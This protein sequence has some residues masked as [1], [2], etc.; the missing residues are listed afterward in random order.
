MPGTFPWSWSVRA[1][2][3]AASNKERLK[4]LAQ[5]RFRFHQHPEAA[6]RATLSLRA[7][8]PWMSPALAAQMGAYGVD[9]ADP[10]VTEVAGMALGRRYRR[11][12]VDGG[13]RRNPN[14]VRNV[15]R[16]AQSPLWDAMD[17]YA[18]P[19]PTL[20][21][22]TRAGPEPIDDA[23]WETA[24]RYSDEEQGVTD[25]YGT[26]SEGAPAPMA[27][28]IGGGLPMSQTQDTSRNLAVEGADTAAA[29]EIA[30]Y[31][32]GID[33]TVS[34]LRRGGLTFQG[35]PLPGGEVSPSDVA[36]ALTGPDR[37]QIRDTLEAKRGQL[38]AQYEGLAGSSYPDLPDGV[39]P[40]MRA[41]YDGIVS[42][43]DDVIAPARQSIGP[44]LDVAGVSLNV[45]DIE[46]TFQTGL[47][48]TVR[49]ATMAMDSLW[50]AGQARFR[51]MVDDPSAGEL[52][53]TLNPLLSV[54]AVVG[55][56][57]TGGERT[58]IADVA[59]QTD[60][61]IT[62]QHLAETGDWADV[63]SGYFV[64]RDSGVGQTRLENEQRHG[65]IGGHVITMGRFAADAAGLEP[66]TVPFDVVSG[67]V[68]LGWILVE[69]GGALVDAA[70]RSGRAGQ[71]LAHAGGF[72]A[73]RSISPAHFDEWLRGD[74]ARVLQ[75]L[76]DL[77]PDDPQQIYRSWQ[78]ASRRGGGSAMPRWAYHDMASGP[79]GDVGFVEEMARNYTGMGYQSP[80][81]PLRDGV[82]P[83]VAFRRRLSE[84]RLAQ[85]SPET[86]D[87]ALDVYDADGFVGML[88]S[89]LRNARVSE[90][91]V[92]RIVFRAYDEGFTYPS[93][94]RV[95]QLERELGEL[96]DE[97][98]V[99]F[100]GEEMDATV[101]RAEIEDTI[102][103]LRPGLFINRPTPNKNVLFQIWEEA[104]KA[105]R[106][107]LIEAGADEGLAIDRTFLAETGRRVD[108]NM[109]DDHSTEGLY[110]LRLV[111][112]DDGSQVADHVRPWA[113]IDGEHTTDMSSPS[114]AHLAAEHLAR[115]LPLEN[116]YRQLARLTRSVPNQV[117]TSWLSSRNTGQ[118]FSA[119]KG[120][121]EIF[122]NRV[123]KP[124]R[125][126][127]PAWPL[128][129][130]G[131]EQFRIAATGF[132]SAIS[133][134]LSFV[135][136][137]MG[138][139][140]DGRIASMIDDAEIGVELA[141][142]GRVAATQL[143]SNTTDA[144][145]R[146]WDVVSEFVASQNRASRN[147][148]I[149]T[150]GGSGG[151]FDPKAYLNAG[152]EVTPGFV[153]AWTDLLARMHSDDIT[154]RV[155]QIELG[156]DS[157]FSSID[158]LIEAGGAA[159][160]NS[161][162]VR[163]AGPDAQGAWIRNTRADLMDAGD[164]RLPLG[165]RGDRTFAERYAAGDDRI[166]NWD[167]YI[168]SVQV[169][170][171]EV[172]G[173]DPELMHT[174]ARGRFS[175]GLSLDTPNTTRINKKAAARLEGDFLDRAPGAVSGDVSHYEKATG[176]TSRSAAV[177]EGYDRVLE[178]MY[179][180]LGATPTDRLSRSPA[181]RQFYLRRMQQLLPN[182]TAEA[183]QQFLRN[184]EE[185][186]KVP[187]SAWHIRLS[188]YIGDAD[189]VTTP[190]LASLRNAAGAGV[191]DLDL[192]F[193][194]ELAKYAALD[195]T[196][197]LLYDV[198]RRGLF[199]DAAR[200][201]FPFGEAWKEVFT[202]WMQLLGQRPG[203]V[204]QRASQVVQAAG[205]EVQPWEDVI[206]DPSQHGFI[207]TNS[208]GEAVFSYPASEWVTAALSGTPV[209][210]TG[211]LNGLTMLNSVIPGL[212]PVIQMPLSASD[213]FRDSPALQG[214]REV[215]FPYGLGD[216]PTDS[217]AGAGMAIADTILSPAAQRFVIG[218]VTAP[219]DDR[220]FLN[221]VFDVMR[222]R[223]SAGLGSTGSESEIRELTQDSQRSAGLLY[224][225]RGLAGMVLPSAPI[226]EQMIE[227][228]NGGPLLMLRALT[229][230][231]RQYQQEDWQTASQ[232][233]LT[234]YGEQ[235]M[236]VIQPKTVATTS[237]LPVTEEADA[238]V[239]SHPGI[240]DEYPLTFGLW[241]PG[242][243]GDSDFDF[244]AYNRYAR[245][246]V[247]RTLGRELSTDDLVYLA[248]DRVASNI[249]RETEAGLL[250]QPDAVTE[251]GNLT[252]EA[253]AYLS[254]TVR[255]DLRNRYPGFGSDGLE[256][257]P[258][259]DELRDAI[260]GP[261]ELNAEVRRAVND[262]RV[263]EPLRDA[264][265]T[266]LEVHDEAMTVW[267]PEQGSQ[268]YY[269]SIGTSGIRTYMRTVVYPGIREDLPAEYQSRWDVIFD[270]LFDRVMLEEGEDPTAN[271][272]GIAA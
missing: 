4:R 90:D 190:T 50:Q 193:A 256:R 229:D 32:P 97:G 93:R 173:R 214:V 58:G 202:R 46:D 200:I 125:L 188:A 88:E 151:R 171:F 116:D 258:S 86:G 205:G 236:L 195:N 99:V 165:Q 266:Y 207:F 244:D 155:A 157:Q 28:G 114:F 199:M 140:R 23:T 271:D 82:A 211:S 16:P 112:R 34:H 179:A 76:A 107:R 66:D 42:A 133:H 215:L 216:D 2:V 187:D 41:V 73:T 62:L 43:L 210:F 160:R 249:Y 269:E 184:A 257:G 185:L 239:Q 177:T 19:K 255:Q 38:E 91:E 74:G 168:E 252:E 218:A 223:V 72:A 139:R 123:W 230:I 267:A 212:G 54:P 265:R 268:T 65:L 197:W 59:Q 198:N 142:G 24:R 176:D 146:P 263:P 240:M 40:S 209:E 161:D 213:W 101:A 158:E 33:A 44:D 95:Q 174:V 98:P 121:D 17:R 208:T 14:E 105:K 18:E 129:V 77:D 169:R 122:M 154:R 201:V 69:P 241:A 251:N 148:I 31:L 259:T 163:L 254:T 137:V 130:V 115:Y 175:D 84:S 150:G 172:T 94:V 228:E 9:V 156:I 20:E 145:G 226:P 242:N 21:L 48:G 250:A 132:D 143:G 248:N 26:A 35:I 108:Q 237:M 96:P 83:G 246:R 147:W 89:S 71:A 192:E 217:W 204:T 8:Y 232:R 36:D 113:Q 170:L 262:E 272:L 221:S 260:G 55:D 166:L 63:G 117:L 79:V 178:R 238:W 70:A 118:L 270:R 110:W 186:M 64:G 57:L 119:W 51:Q 203:T 245:D 227:S 80:G 243:T 5:D 222:Y 191:G 144:L 87:R 120:I 53:T 25:F 100:R 67:L 131:E 29:R 135:S 30:P 206:E 149:P 27:G 196:R 224:M 52:F 182:M 11:G 167:D 6:A 106:E 152:G 128:R 45:G 78:A 111:T 180:L 159:A 127:R 183:Q 103:E 68:D 75:H 124:S 60:L 92:A 162:E 234:D 141:T 81:V 261:N 134:P 220:L 3:E 39:T 247:I 56:A 15:T 37:D 225:V 253:Q 235:M 153:Q 22:G 102:A 7:A 264:L 164:T 194:D 47:R 13:G 126:L 10:G 85:Q 1:E 138:T 12:W 231:Y 136:L 109:M 189:D 104:Q 233:F 181:F 61:G 49:T 219:A